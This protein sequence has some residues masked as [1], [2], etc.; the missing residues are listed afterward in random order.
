MSEVQIGH[1]VW[2]ESGG[3]Y[4]LEVVLL[5]GEL[6][7]AHFEDCVLIFWGRNVFLSGSTMD[8]CLMLKR[9]M[10]GGIEPLR[11]GQ[12]HIDRAIELGGKGWSDEKIAFLEERAGARLSAYLPERTAND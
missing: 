10:F 8:R 5:E 1:K 4:L 12:K 6:E 7:D 2:A 3:S 11:F 9:N